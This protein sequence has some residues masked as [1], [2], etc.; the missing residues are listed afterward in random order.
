MTNAMMM[1]RRAL[2]LAVAA[3]AACGRAVPP[4]AEAAQ[5]A[6]GQ[7]ADSL[8]LLRAAEPEDLSQAEVLRA[9][10]LLHARLDPAALASGNHAFVHS[11]AAAA[12][13]DSMRRMVAAGAPSLRDIGAMGD[14]VSAPAADPHFAARDALIRQALLLQERGRA[15]TGVRDA[16]RALTAPR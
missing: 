5:R 6:P 8:L 13:I 4:D 15:E 14:R 1:L 2:V 7:D 10:S 3:T 11:R 9:D 12:A 16:E